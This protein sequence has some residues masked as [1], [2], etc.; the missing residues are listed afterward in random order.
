HVH[1]V[2]ENDDNLAGLMAQGFDAQWNDDAHHVLHRILTGET[3]GYYMAYRDD[4]TGQLARCL[5]EGFVYQGQPSPWRNGQPRGEPSAGLAPSSFVFFLQNHD[6]TGNRAMGERLI[7]LCRPDALRAAAAVQ[8][9]AP[10]I[11]ML[12]MGEEHGARE[13]FQY[14]TSFA[15]PQLAQA[16]RDGRRREFAGFRE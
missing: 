6:Q 9:L 7:S 2:L 11:P 8:M 16:V 1:L 14:F 15:D 5:A 13:P 3:Q 10:H 12:F 4:P